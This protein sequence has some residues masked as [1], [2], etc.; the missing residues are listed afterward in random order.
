MSAERERAVKIATVALRRAMAGDLEGAARYIERLSGTDGLLIAIVA[1]IDTYAARV[2]P[3]WEPGGRVAVKWLFT[4]T[5]QMETA[6]EVA[7]SMR[8]AG[9]LIA[10]RLADDEAG[11][12]AVLRSAP[13]GVALG[14]GIMAL[15]HIV[16]T[17]LKDPGVVRAA[18][19]RST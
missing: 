15:V 11:F 3:E 14:D 9:R 17:G 4:P 8:W 13:E 12:Y 5:G 6:D 7:P 19:G 18:E 2:Y 16:A 10:A 1:W